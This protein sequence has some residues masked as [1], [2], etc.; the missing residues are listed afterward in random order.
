[1]SD[2]IIS[3]FRLLEGIGQWL[4]QYVLRIVDVRFG[5]LTDISQTDRDVRLY[6]ESR[7]EFEQKTLNFPPIKSIQ[8][9]DRRLATEDGCQ[10]PP[11]GDLTPR[12][13]RA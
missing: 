3:C 5:S 9:R 4:A 8:I 10:V 13:L 6:P 11:R 12:R 1:M 2:I 7:H